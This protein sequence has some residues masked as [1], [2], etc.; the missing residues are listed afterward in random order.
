M[1]FLLVA[2][3]TLLAETLCMLKISVDETFQLLVL[4]SVH[5]CV[6]SM[7]LC[8]FDQI[9]MHT[10]SAWRLKFEYDLVKSHVKTYSSKLIMLVKMNL[11]EQ[12]LEDLSLT[13][14]E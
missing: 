4:K 7:L 10:C 11:F 2:K 1:V 5:L 14:F 8:Q 3:L 6:D 13:A 9:S 12:F